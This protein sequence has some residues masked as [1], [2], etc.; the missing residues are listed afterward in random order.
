MPNGRPIY[1]AVDGDTR[2][3]DS[4]AWAAINAFFAAAGGV[5]GVGRI[6]VYGG[7]NT[8]ERI[9]AAGLATWFWQTYAWSAGQWA[10]GIHLRQYDNSNPICGGEVDYDRAMTADYGQW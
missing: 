10:D 2:L 4:V 8:I 9:R 6:G 1:F 7:I 5:L 3:L